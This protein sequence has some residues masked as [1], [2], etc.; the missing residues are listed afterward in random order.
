[1]NLKYT[2]VL[3]AG[4]AACKHENK[5][6]AT[7][8]QVTTRAD[9]AH[10]FSDPKQAVVKHLNLKLTVDF[11]K[12]QICGMADWAISAKKGAKTIIF[13]TNDLQIDSVKVDGDSTSYSLGHEDEFLGRPLNVK[14]NSA[15]KRVSIW[16]KT[17]SDAAALQ[18][19]NPQQTADKKYPFLF[20]QS[21]AILAR[22]WVPCQDSPGIRFT[23]D[24][25][26]S[27]PKELMAV[28]SASNVT[29]KNTSGTYQFNQKN[30]IPSYLMALAVGDL[31]FRSL[32]RNTGVYAEPSVIKKAAWE[33]EG[34]QKMMDS[35]EK[36]YGKYRWGRYDVLVLPPSFPFGGMENPELT[37]ATPTIIAGD[38]SLVS[39]LAHELA[40]SW[41]GNLVTNATWNDMWL[42]EGF[43]NYFE[44][45]IMEKMEGKNYADM[46]AQLGFQELQGT[47][48][49]L[50]ATNPDTKL[51]LDLKGRN[52]DDG[53]TDIAYEKGYCLLRV[54]ENAA[55]RER[56]DAFLNKYFAS[57]A[58]QTITTEEFINYYYKELIKGDKALGDKIAIEKWVYEPGLPDNCPKFTS[59]RFDEVNK[60]LEQW[61]NGT[62]ASA[63][64]TNAWSS[65]EWLHFV[66]H[67]P[68]NITTTQMK[69]LD[70]AFH[71]TQSGNSE[72]LGAW[73]LLSV[74]KR[75]V[76]AYP[77]LN[78]FLE[79]VGRRRFILPIYKQLA[80]SE[81]GKKM[82][83]DIYS[84][85]RP[86]YHYV[87][88]ESI[89][90]LLK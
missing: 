6:Q 16:Y 44:R 65:H 82:A 22:S 1:M 62:A 72:V 79:N 60:A 10:S 18:W 26:V 55:G 47:L 33:F 64:P 20:T 86:N 3:A 5:P 85:A 12:K 34:L 58:F 35:A 88:Q 15:S 40:H 17:S 42:N 59:A 90:N 30:A 71:F 8:Q 29:Q 78:T 51:K 89:D 19:L 4:L 77:A 75:Y 21:E 63:L 11:D 39:L 53:L 43:T 37:F 84:K 46:L 23:Y 54:M 56:F 73:L 80:A 41:S 45:R 70:K 52:P 24:A 61:I 2:I 50:G 66:R 25:K 67:L 14:I 57:H 48:Q 32:G 7:Q 27:V 87:A 74:K 68:E 28:M 13:D 49:D 9:D 69:E 31:E 76:A 81:D 36:L 83:K 38:R